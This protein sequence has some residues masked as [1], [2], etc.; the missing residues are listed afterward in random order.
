LNLKQT[1]SLNTWNSVLYAFP[2][3]LE[4]QNNF[5]D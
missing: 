5:E 2:N 4:E 1:N 3:H